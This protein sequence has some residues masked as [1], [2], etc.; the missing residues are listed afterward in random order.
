MA[1]P[2]VG[3]CADSK[4][5]DERYF[6][7]WYRN[8][9]TRVHTP[10]AVRRKV[11]MVLAVTEHFL[12][13]EVRNA[14]DIGAGEGTWRTELR[15]LRPGLDYTGIDSSEYVIRRYGRRRNIQ[16]GRFEDLPTMSLGGKYDLIVCADLL[17]YVATSALERGAHHIA[18]MLDG[19]AFLESYTSTDEKDMTG[20][21]SR[22]H[23]RTK[24]KHR[25]IFA[26]AGLVACGMHCYVTGDLAA[27]AAELELL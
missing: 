23:S 27:G 14:L 17:Q 20:D 2:A 9:Q 16:F 6:R 10:D 19:L 8:P 5:Y 11:R 12:G 1:T 22:W 3:A 25:R 13:R 15:R 26:D 21:L 24:A 18:G 7:K 4:V